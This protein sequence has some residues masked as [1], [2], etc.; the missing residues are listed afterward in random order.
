MPFG[1]GG[2]GLAGHNAFLEYQILFLIDWWWDPGSKKTWTKIEHQEGWIL[3]SNVYLATLTTTPYINNKCALSIG[4]QCQIVSSHLSPWKKGNVFSKY[5]FHL[6]LNAR[7]HRVH[8]N[9]A[10]F[11]R[12]QRQSWSLIGLHSSRYLW[13]LQRSRKN[14]N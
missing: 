6:N 5:L 12:S 8:S 9:P 7:I 11:T 13:F 1:V 4:G 14:Q 10:L 2:L 3:L